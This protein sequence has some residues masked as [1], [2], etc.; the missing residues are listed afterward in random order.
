[1]GDMSQKA[2]RQNYRV[3]LRKVKSCSKSLVIRTLQTLGGTRLKPTL[4]LKIYWMSP[5]KNQ[6]SLRHQRLMLFSVWVARSGR[7]TT[8]CRVWPLGLQSIF[9]IDLRKKDP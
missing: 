5:G 7:D 9:F 4:I 6:T 8:T 2:I 1:M 3:I